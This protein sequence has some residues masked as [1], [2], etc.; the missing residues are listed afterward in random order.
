M[1]DEQNP[2]DEDEE[3]QFNS[4]FS[5]NPKFASGANPSLQSG[6]MQMPRKAI[7]RK[8]KPTSEVEQPQNLDYGVYPDAEEEGYKKYAKA[9]ARASLRTRQSKSP[10]PSGG[11]GD[12]PIKVMLFQL[13][14]I[15]PGMGIHVEERKRSVDQDKGFKAPPGPDFSGPRAPAQ[16]S[17]PDFKAAGTINRKNALDDL[18]GRDFGGRSSRDAGALEQSPV[19]KFI[20]K[21][22]GGSNA[23]AP[24]QEVEAPEVK[25]KKLLIRIGIIAVVL[26]LVSIGYNIVPRQTQ[27]YDTFPREF[28]SAENE[29]S[30]K[31]IDP[32][33]AVFAIGSDSAKTPVKFFMNDLRDYADVMFTVPFQKQIWLVKTDRGVKDIDS[34]FELYEQRSKEYVVST[35]AQKIAERVTAYY[36]KN[37]SYPTS[38]EAVGK[39]F[40]PY[41]EKQQVVQVKQIT[42]GNTKSGEDVDQKKLDLYK[43]LIFA[44]SK[45]E[46][47]ETAGD[48]GCWNVKYISAHQNLNIFIIKPYG[49]NGESILGGH[50][51]AQFFIA[52]EDG[53]PKELLAVKPLFEWTGKSGI[54]PLTT[55]LF[56]DQLNPMLLLLLK[57]SAKVIFTILAF[58]SLGFLLSLKKGE[59]P[60]FWIVMLVITGVPAILA[61]FGNFI[62]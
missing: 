35:E 40:N 56:A 45:I 54:R 18:A 39:Y 12:N 28:R 21:I 6:E 53:Q 22:F 13:A 20:E 17:T 3:E 16:P 49:T 30:F 61:I 42:D 48:I 9:P 43:E 41:T 38:S 8:P 55:I 47:K 36:A 4:Q 5:G 10:A 2:Y 25:Q 19:E 62:P 46:A 33:N 44:K 24:V 29:K 14:S 26:I 57:H 15:M 31:V 59:S 37:H 34:N 23:D 27:L 60:I 52:I 50:P 7:P 1:P 32:A 51:D 58:G 11:G